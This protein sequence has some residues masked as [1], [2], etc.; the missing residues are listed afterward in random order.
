MCILTSLFSLEWLLLYLI[1]L[2]FTRL[3]EEVK[4][5]ECEI[6]NQKDSLCFSRLRM[7]FHPFTAPQTAWKWHGILECLECFLFYSYLHILLFNLD[8]MKMVKEIKQIIG[9]C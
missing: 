3:K 8:E 4:E 1:I 2:E 5:I 9:I 6:K 7:C